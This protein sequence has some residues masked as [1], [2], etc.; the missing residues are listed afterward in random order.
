[1]LLTTG[2]LLEDGKAGRSP[3]GTWHNIQSEQDANKRVMLIRTFTWSKGK[4]NKE[5]RTRCHFLYKPVSRYLISISE[6]TTGGELYQPRYPSGKPIPDINI[7]PR[8][9]F[10]SVWAPQSWGSLLDFS[11]CAA[12]NVFYPRGGRKSSNENFNRQLLP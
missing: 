10:L 7:P 12:R 9:Q 6:I 2:H 3:H 8:I 11:A 4:M 5:Q 1:M